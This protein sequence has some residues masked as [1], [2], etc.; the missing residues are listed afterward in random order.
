LGDSV[1]NGDSILFGTGN[2]YVAD[3]DP[4]AGNNTVYSCSTGTLASAHLATIWSGDTLWGGVW[5]ETTI[6]GNTCYKASWTPSRYNPSGYNEN[7]PCIVGG[8][9]LYARVATRAGVTSVG[10]YHYDPTNDL[11]YIYPYI[12]GDPDVSGHLMKASLYPA[13]ILNAD[14]DSCVFFGLNLKMGYG[15]TV[16]VNTGQT[17]PQVDQCLFIHCN[18]AHNTSST[19][20]NSSVV[21]SENYGAPAEPDTMDQYHYGIK[22]IACTLYSANSY[23]GATGDSHA[24]SGCTFYGMRQTVFDSCHFSL[25]PG[26]GVM[27]KGGGNQYYGNRVS[28][29]TFDGTDQM[30]WGDNTFTKLGVEHACGA[31]RDS[32]FGCIFINL[33]NCRAMGVREGD[34][35][36][37]LSQYYMGDFICNNSFYNCDGFLDT[38]NEVPE[39][40]D[41]IFVFKYNVM[42][43]VVNGSSRWVQ[44][45]QGGPVNNSSYCDIDSNMWYDSSGGNNF[46]WLEYPSTNRYWAYW[47]ATMGYDAN[48]DTVDA[49]YNSPPSDLSR[50]GASGEMN[51]TYGGRTWTIFGATQNDAGA[52]ASKVAIKR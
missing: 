16:R 21:F 9:S 3:L 1:V 11:L 51:R 31:D 4:P 10:Y 45:Y 37:G 30:P 13:V 24:G 39:D 17:L 28:F 52:S 7:F 42:Q 32:V 18:L 23:V 33:V 6:G 35:N 2:W 36:Q 8:D 27:W 34:C 50:P 49:G 40:A 20:N 43:K 44:T 47:T 19:A 15:G 25:F 38:Y 5:A 26:A 48:G 46:L 22:F 12:S 14:I 29:C 41:S